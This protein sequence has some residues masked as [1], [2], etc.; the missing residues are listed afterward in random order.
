[1]ESRLSGTSPVGKKCRGNFW[2]PAR[3]GTGGTG[4]NRHGEGA[5]KMRVA[6]GA[7]L[8]IA[9][10][11]PVAHADD[12]HLANDK[13]LC[14]PQNLLFEGVT[15]FDPEQVRHALK[16]C[17]ALNSAANPEHSVVRYCVLVRRSIAAGYA[18]AGFAD[19]KI[20]VLA[21][22]A[23]R[24]VVARVNEGTRYRSG[25]VQVTGLPAQAAEEL[26]EA[27]VRPFAPLTATEVSFPR[28]DGRASTVWIEPAGERAT[29]GE[30]VWKPGA[31]VACDAIAL[32]TIRERVQEHFLA[33]G[34]ESAEFDVR[35]EPQG[36]GDLVDLIIAVQDP[37]L[38][39]VVSQIVIDGLQRNSRDALV[40]LLDI[41]PGM[42][43]DGRLAPRLQRRL[44]DSGRFLAAHVMRG[45]VF[46]AEDRANCELRIMLK[47]H[48]L[49]PLLGDRLTP[50]EETLLK[51]NNWFARW[52]E[53]ET[54]EDMVIKVAINGAEFPF[55]KF[56]FLK[57]ISEATLQ[58]VVSSN[59]GSLM[60]L[61][62]RTGDG[63]A[64]AQSLL[65]SGGRIAVS[66]PLHPSRYEFP[67]QLESLD[68]TATIT[69]RAGA[70]RE[71]DPAYVQNEFRFSTGVYARDPGD[72]AP[73]L[74]LAVE[75]SLLVLRSREGRWECQRNAGRATFRGDYVALIVD[76]RT[77]RLE[78]LSAVHREAGF[79]AEIH[80]ERNALQRELAERDR[81]LAGAANGFDPER[82][83]QSALIYVLDEYQHFAAAALKADDLESLAAFRK[84]LMNWVPV[85]DTGLPKPDGGHETSLVFSIPARKTGAGQK[86]TG[87]E[88]SGS[89][90]NSTTA[91]AD[92]HNARAAGQA[93]P[94]GKADGKDESIDEMLVRYG[95]TRSD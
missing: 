26:A 15:S 89:L 61:G 44:L 62:C 75:P 30:A 86:T 24:R 19:A 8:W 1:M 48:P 23:A 84:L 37:G 10:L 72:H 54:A 47:E 52:T 81:Q 29:M 66:S 65:H 31:P 21:D 82:P 83:W 13:V 7:L 11:G 16:V 56:P 35:V 57:P 43:F 18:H 70:P 55:F 9:I 74:R 5:R 64:F 58:G 85:C 95:S 42:A 34:R 80:F 68:A 2:S 22:E 77:G 51:L 33:C 71:S 36:R 25:E 92:G 60:T 59:G 88:S 14:D 40:T 67:K 20:H 78:S 49:L 93:K 87:L 6:M 73:Q 90:L 38:P 69:I 28:A 79:D 53:G 4:H 39:A 32:E 63:R 45:N 76:E 91:R 94:G 46:G 41:E 27:L 50:D 3:L 12:R 17:S